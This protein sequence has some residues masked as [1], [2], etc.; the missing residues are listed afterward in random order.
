MK[1]NM[2]KNGRTNKM[3]KKFCYCKNCNFFSSKNN[4]CKIPYKLIKDELFFP[5]PFKD[6]RK[7]DCK[8]Y[9]SEIKNE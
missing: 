1:V 7:H 6:N 9:S 4:P 8:F 3:K 2:N 5:F